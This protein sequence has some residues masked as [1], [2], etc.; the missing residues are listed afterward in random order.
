ML[1]NLCSPFKAF[2][3]RFVGERYGEMTRDTSQADALARSSLLTLLAPSTVAEAVTS[4]VAAGGGETPQA[5]TYP[6]TP[7]RPRSRPRPRPTKTEGC[8]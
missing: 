4:S 5:I 8:V 6:P 7:M 3:T 1:G 2:L